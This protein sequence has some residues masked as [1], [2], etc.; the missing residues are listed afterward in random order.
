M[1]WR[2]LFLC[3]ILFFMVG[4]T[5]CDKEAYIIS[6]Q[7]IMSKWN[8]QEQLA[9]STS[10][11]NL[12]DQIGKLQEIKREASSL[13]IDTCFEEAHGYLIDSFE[14]EIKAFLAFMSDESDALVSN[15]FEQSKLN[16]AIWGELLSDIK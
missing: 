5:T 12:G 13:D 16:I 6:I 14:A 9:N 15:L 10:R 3:I 11:I 1:K 4:C 2:F 7:P 8:D